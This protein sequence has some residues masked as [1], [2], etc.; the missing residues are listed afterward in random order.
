MRNCAACDARNTSTANAFCADG[1]IA[2]AIA[3]ASD[4]DWFTY[5]VAAGQNYYV[6]LSALPA[7]YNFTVYKLVNG[8]LSTIGTAPDN[9]DRADQQLARNTPSGGTY[10]VKVFGVNGATSAARY[11]LAVH[12]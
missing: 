3:S 5:S 1:R 2:G 8:A 7:D 11:S 10:F 4:V 9:H 6:T 12:N